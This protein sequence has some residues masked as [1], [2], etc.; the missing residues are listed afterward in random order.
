MIFVKW[1]TPVHQAH[2][3]ILQAVERIN[4]EFETG[5]PIGALIFVAC[6]HSGEN[7]MSMICHAGG[8]VELQELMATQICRNMVLTP[9]IPWYRRLCY[10]TIWKLYGIPA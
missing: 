4:H 9:C 5:I 8:F 10:W 6:V 1:T 3:S 7:R 2:S